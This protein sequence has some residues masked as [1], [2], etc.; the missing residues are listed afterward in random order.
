MSLKKEALRGFI[1][2]YAEQSGGQII[3]F[4]VNILLARTLFPADFG[5]LGLL[6]VFITIANVLVDGGMKI[7]IIRK[8]EVTDRDYTSVFFANILMSCVLYT[9]IFFLAPYISEFYKKPEL[10]SIVRV[11]SITIVL[12]AF[13]FVQS[14]ILTK[15]LNFRQQSLMKIPSIILSSAIGI[16]LALLHFGVWSLV[17]MY[18][19]QTFF[20][21]LFHWIFSDWKPKLVFDKSLFKYHFN[22]G[23]KLTLVEVLNAIISNAYQIVI[24]KY[25]NVLNVGYYTQSLTL[26]QLPISNIYGPASKLFL[27]IFSKIQ[28][29]EDRVVRTYQQIISVLIVVVAPILTFLAVFSEQIIV[30]LYSEKWRV[31][32]P[33]LFHLAV[34]G[35]FTVVCSFNLTVLNIIG[36][37][38]LLLKIEF[39]NKIQIILFIIATIF[40]GLPIKYLLYTISISAIVSYFIVTFFATK[41]LKI[42][43]LQQLFSFVRLLSIVVIAVFFAYILFT[44]C[45]Q[46][47]FLQFGNLLL[48]IALGLSLYVGLTF[49]F[50]RSIVNN[51]L[52]LLKNGN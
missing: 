31:A 30:F 26:R 15:N 16:I 19:T 29:D 12:Q 48:S 47:I 7:S 43:F 8:K 45:F 40:L 18:L 2:T 4:F 21:A 52:D 38:K 17:W 24:G 36:G 11:F 50:N 25:Y 34:A 51:L 42:D 5:I 22:F 39:I 9:I 14:A 13:V 27:P 10:V 28:D 33:F 37:S 41:H 20:W 23:Y 32:A 3:N 46:S 1:W 35:I 6:F 49:L 44:F